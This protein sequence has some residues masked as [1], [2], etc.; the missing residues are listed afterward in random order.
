MKRR[1]I[2]FTLL[3]VLSLGGQAQDFGFGGQ[4]RNDVQAQFSMKYTDIDYVGDGQ[5][6]HSLDLYVPQTPAPKKGY[7]VVV[8]IY[9]SAWYSNNS[10]GAA[11]INTICKA[12]LDAGYAVVCPNHRSSGDAQYP[13]QIQD[14]KA[15]VRWIRGNADRLGL[16]AS[17]IGTSG[18]S[19]GAHLASLCAATNGVGVA[20]KGSAQ[21]DIEGNLGAYTSQ[22]SDVQACCEWSGPIDLTN[23]DCAGKRNMPHSPEEAVMGFDYSGH[24]D[25]YALLSPIHYLSEQTVPILVCHGVADNVVPFCQ[26]QQFYNEIV[27]HKVP[28]CGFIQQAGGGHG[29]NMYSPENL[30]QMVRHFDNARQGVTRSMIVEQGGTGK[31]PAVME[32]FRSLPAHTVFCPQDLSQ[33]DKKHPLPVLVWGNGACTDSP[34]EHF[35]FLNEIASQGYLVIATGYLPEKEEPY[36]GPM[37]TP[38]QQI[39]SIDWAIAQN[40]NPLS[41]LF[42][43]VDT[44][45][46]CASGM[47]CGGLQTLYNCA[48]KRI[49]CYMI[50]NSGLFMDPSIA[51]PGMPMPGKEQ[52][53][54]VHGPIIY[55]MGGETDI[56]YQNGMDDYHRIHHVPAVAVNYPVGHGGT[57][58]QPYG[59]EFRYPAVAWLNWQLKGDKQAAKWFVGD[60]PLLMQREKWALERNKKVK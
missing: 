33:F 20:K 58:R 11:D 37:S 4:Q 46:I 1:N 54:K 41:P 10:K 13:A 40:S 15:V 39:Q 6:Y 17:F 18:F 47:S 52:L 25:A 29:F 42:G 45:A 16:D 31:Y 36:K 55:I 23:M 22:S 19:S 30:A 38:Q 49:R 50:C 8:H 24:E 48:D 53:N 2:L 56:A 12:L 51:M 21:Y 57:Y 5:G 27:A 32:E 9:G 60:H 3:L 59:G 28:G 7:P 14:I 26:G 34:W 43:K 44:K 35:K